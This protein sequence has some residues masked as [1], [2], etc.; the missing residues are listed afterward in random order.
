MDTSVSRTVCPACGK[1]DAFQIKYKCI[2][3]AECNYGMWF[4]TEFVRSLRSLSV[5]AAGYGTKQAK[6]I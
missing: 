6:H 2:K 1:S 5:R 4:M 3:L